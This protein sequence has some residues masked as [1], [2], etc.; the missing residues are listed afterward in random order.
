MKTPNTTD[1]PIPYWPTELHAS[2]EQEYLREQL[3]MLNDLIAHVRR[4]EADCCL[5]PK[6]AKDAIVRL[7]SERLDLIDQM[8]GNAQNVG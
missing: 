5:S 8:K 7:A 6:Y 3:S 2:A 1:T 4:G